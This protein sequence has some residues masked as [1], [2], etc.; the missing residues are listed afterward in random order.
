MV[1]TLQEYEG[2]WEELARHAE[3]FNGRRLRLVVLSE[4]AAATPN[5]KPKMMARA[6]LIPKEEWRNVPPDFVDRLDEYLYGEQ[7]A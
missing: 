2:T 4:P 6:A 3:E 1:E 7:A 5:D